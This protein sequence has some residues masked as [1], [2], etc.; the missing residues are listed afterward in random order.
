MW[1]LTKLKESLGWIN[2]GSASK[3]PSEINIQGEQVQ[4]QYKREIFC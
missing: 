3:R 4:I 2:Q 1:L